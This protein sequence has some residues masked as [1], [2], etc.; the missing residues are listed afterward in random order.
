M[1][2]TSFTSYGRRASLKRRLAAIYLSF[3][4]TSQPYGLINYIE[5]KA[6]CHHLKLLS[7][8]G[9]LRQVL[10]RFCRLEIQYSQVFFD[11]A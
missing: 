9:I 7:C 8:K 11:Q 1:P 6:K 10:I 4:P 5:T 2:I 3:L